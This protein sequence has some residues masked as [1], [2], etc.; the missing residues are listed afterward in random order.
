MPFEKERNK[1]SFQEND[2]I[3]VSSTRY[4]LT[5]YYSSSKDKI[6]SR[7]FF[8]DEADT[9]KI[10]GCEK[11]NASF[12]WFIT[13]TFNTLCNPCGVK[14]FVNEETGEARKFYDYHHGFTKVQYIEGIKNTGFIKQTMMSFIPMVE[15]NIWTDI[16]SQ[17]IVKNHDNY[18]KQAFNLPDY[19]THILESKNPT[20]LFL[21]LKN[22]L[23]KNRIILMVVI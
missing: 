4:N 2:I 9:I 10:P 17:L 18:V 12:T 16:K 8:F 21:F 5:G 7:I 15:I 1:L 20:S 19:I 22:L 14:Y 23:Q 13:S 11:L 6:F 3:L